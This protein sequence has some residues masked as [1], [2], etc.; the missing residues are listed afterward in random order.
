MIFKKEAFEIL[1]SRNE[2]FVAANYVRKKSSLPV[3]QKNAAFVFSK[4]QSGIEQITNIGL[5]LALMKVSA[6]RLTSKPHFEV[7]WS[8]ALNDYEGEDTYFCTKLAKAGVSL[9]VDHDATRYVAHIG[10]AHYQE[11]FTKKI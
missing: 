11:P 6:L 10:S 1:L 8:D 9:Y 3:T 7:L 5:G 2:D 4:D